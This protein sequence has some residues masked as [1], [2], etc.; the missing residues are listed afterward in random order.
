MPQTARKNVKHGLLAGAA[1]TKIQLSVQVLFPHVA[2]EGSALRGF[3]RTLL[4][5]KDRITAVVEHDQALLA[6]WRSAI[7]GVSGS[8]A[9]KFCSAVEH[10]LPGDFHEIPG[11]L[12][13]A[14]SADGA[15][16]GE[17]DEKAR[18]VEALIARQ[19]SMKELADHVQRLATGDARFDPRTDVF[20]GEP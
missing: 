16:R 11:V 20:T 5:G 2:P 14:R 17:F 8:G 7:E 13:L 15:A 19:A 9:A 6:L 3:V 4:R 10:A 12:E 18:Q 1:A